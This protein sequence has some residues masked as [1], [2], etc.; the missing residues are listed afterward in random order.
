MRQLHFNISAIVLAVCIW[1]PGCSKQDVTGAN[2][3]KSPELAELT[4]QVRS[5]SLEKRKL[6]QSMEDL[7]VAGY[8]QSVPSAPTGKKYAIDADRAQA[9]LVDR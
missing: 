7:L 5:Y 9:V 3:L 6:P 8:I 1:I 2:A 4:K